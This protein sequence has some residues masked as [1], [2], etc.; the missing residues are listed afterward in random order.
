MSVS[1]GTVPAVKAVSL[2]VP[3]GS[4]V[5]LLGANGAGK[6]S[7]LLA[8]AGHLAPSAGVAHLLG[9]RIK[10]NPRA[11]VR[12]GL[13]LVPE[14]RCLFYSLTASENLRLARRP[15]GMTLADVLDLFPKLTVKMPLLAGTMSG[16]E[17][18]MLALA[19]ALVQGP[20]VILIDELSL[21]L[22]P[23]VVD[24][25]LSCLR[26]LVTQSGVSVLLVEQHVPKALEVADFAYVMSRGRIIMAAGA[27]E[28]SAR[29]DLIEACYM[30]EAAMQA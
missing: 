30:G 2:E 13:S 27:A 6:T 17:Q 14:D 24:D 22:A 20:K 18:Q 5:A 16:G 11:L 25:L 7:T 21:G 26:T 12:R 23:L 8:L 29:P 10:P 15:G 4:L 28:L 1:Y 3:A 9:E 19:R